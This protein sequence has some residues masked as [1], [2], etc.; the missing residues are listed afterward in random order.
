MYK[1]CKIESSKRRQQ[2]FVD[3][4]LQLLEKTAWPKVTVQQLCR[5]LDVPRNA[6]Y[7]YFDTLDD[8]L[9]LLINRHLI[10]GY[11]SYIEQ[12][13][14]EHGCLPAGREMV[15]LFHFWHAKRRLLDMLDKNGLLDRMLGRLARYDVAHA[16]AELRSRFKGNIDKVESAVAFS[17][18]GLMALV[19]QWREHGYQPDE[20]EMAQYALE[21]MTQ[22]LFPQ[23]AK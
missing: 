9:D 22:P 2:A 23:Q 11:T 12:C 3:G 8:V 17:V 10:R 16:S 19:L 15:E 20:A 18:S 1:S 6:F 5:S 7:R 14:R 13:A 21:F 4:L